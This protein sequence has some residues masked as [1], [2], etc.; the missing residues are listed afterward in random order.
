MYIKFITF[1]SDHGTKVYW[2]A[3]GTMSAADGWQF[4]CD[5]IVADDLMGYIFG[6]T[7]Y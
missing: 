3:P 5:E 7:M 2:F 6:T 1:E 4:I